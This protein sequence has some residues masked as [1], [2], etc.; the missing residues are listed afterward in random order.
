[1]SE[2]RILSSGSN[3]ALLLSPLVFLQDLEASQR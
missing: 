3:V 1:M 2:P